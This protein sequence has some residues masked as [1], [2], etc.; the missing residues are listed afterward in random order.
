MLASIRPVLDSRIYVYCTMPEGEEGGIP[1]VFRFREKEGL[2]LVTSLETAKAH[3]LEYAYPCRLITL[4]VHSSLEAV[5]FLAAI[6]G[7][8]A[9]GGV[10]ANAVSAF[11][12]D[13]LF[14]PV[15]SAEKAM[16][17]LGEFGRE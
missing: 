11:Y 9:G 2:T 10:S 3:G 15:E 1:H 5:G 12:H 17:L 14:V 8:L 4:N 7:K 6:T 13:Y 16:D